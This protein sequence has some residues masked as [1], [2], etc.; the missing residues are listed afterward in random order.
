VAKTVTTREGDTVT[1]THK[2]GHVTTYTMKVCERC[3]EEY[4]SYC[5]YCNNSECNIAM[6]REEGCEEHLPNGLPVRCVKHNGLMLEHEHGDHPD[7]VFPVDIEY[8][9][10]ITDSDRVDY[11][12]FMPDDDEPAS[13]DK[14]RKSMCETHALIYTDGCVVV[15][16]Y[17]CC[18]AMWYLSEGYKE[19]AGMCGGGSLWKKNE[20]KLT[21]ESIEKIKDHAK[22]L[23]NEQ[24]DNT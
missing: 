17:E 21:D 5:N 7:Y 4:P 2:D 23:Y 1:V 18:Y 13:D 9:G 19:P 24:P 8:V 12:Y 15:T 11:E 10:D 14:V 22:R 6:W 16:M 3:G 20:W